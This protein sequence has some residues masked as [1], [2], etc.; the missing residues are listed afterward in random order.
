MDRAIVRTVIRKSFTIFLVLQVIFLLNIYPFTHS[1]EIG[2]HQNDKAL[3]I[4]DHVSSEVN[5]PEVI[6]DHSHQDH[7]TDCHHDKQECHVELVTQFLYANNFTSKITIST[8]L[9]VCAKFEEAV[10]ETNCYEVDNEVVIP[11]VTQFFGSTVTQRG[12]PFSA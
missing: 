7:T 1:H 3:H 11:C 4:C 9:S 8:S 10:P 12:P 6:H 5:Q 2:H